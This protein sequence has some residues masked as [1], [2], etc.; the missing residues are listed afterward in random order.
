MPI[1]E[2]RCG[3]CGHELEALQKL[4]E[5][6]LAECPQC[7][8]SALTKLISPVGFQLKG[9][10]W[11]ATDFKGSGKPADKANGNNGEAKSNEGKSESADSK[12][13][14]PAE[15]KTPAKAET[16]STGSSGGCGGG[17]SCH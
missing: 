5:P 15:S 4:S 3:A 2:Y 6:P 10:G 17:C 14:S 13:D 1:Y 12:S 9:S 7:H 16:T 8:E 11:Y